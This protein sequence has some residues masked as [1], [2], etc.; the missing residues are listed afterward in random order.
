VT[1][2][3]STANELSGDSV[4]NLVE[5]FTYVDQ[6]Q[7][8]TEGPDMGP[9]PQHPSQN[10]NDGFVVTM[11]STG[12]YDAN[13]ASQQFVTNANNGQTGEISGATQGD[14]TQQQSTASATGGASSHPPSASACSLAVS[15]FTLLA[16]LIAVI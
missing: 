14:A 3:S 8:N 16:C 4:D 7:V 12:D 11:C 1:V 5:Y 9:F 2:W 10:G 15:L 6:S 13:G